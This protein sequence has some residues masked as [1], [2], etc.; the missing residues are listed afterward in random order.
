MTSSAVTRQFASALRKAGER[1]KQDAKQK[2]YFNDPVFWAE[3][4]LGL[5]LWSGQKKIL[6]S[7]AVN[8][9]TAVKSCHSIGKTFISAVASAWWI[10]TRDN[11]MVQS[12][13]PT[14]DQVHTLL[15]EEIRK[16]HNKAGLIGRVN[17]QDQWLKDTVNPETGRRQ[18]IV[19]GQGKKPADGN[20]HGF[21]GM[22]RPDGVFAIYDE[23]CGIAQA[24]FT[25]GEAITTGTQ[26]RQLTVGNPDDPATEFGDIFTTKGHLWNL[27]TISAYDTPNFTNE[28]EE[29]RKKYRNDPDKLAMVEAMLMGMPNVDTVAEQEELWGEDSPRFQSKVL[30]Q[31]PLVSEDSLFTPAEMATGISNRLNPEEN[32]FKVLGVDP[33]RYGNDKAAIALCDEGKVE[34]VATYNTMDLMELAARVHKFAIDL[35]VDQVRVDAV[36]L[37]GG[38]LDRL[39]ALNNAAGKTY[40][41]IE[42]IAGATPPDR[43]LHRNARA[44]WYDSFKHKLR[45]GNI[46]LP[47]S[48]DLLDEMSKVRYEYPNGVMKIESKEDMRKRGVHSP[49]ILDAVV[50][51]AAPIT[52]IANNPLA[53]ARPGQQFNFN[54]LERVRSVS[55]F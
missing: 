34:I 25:G 30:A 24:I 50:M 26:D 47:D 2:A 54:L 19:V 38:V 48:K 44:Y 41:V 52:S 53:S 15:W 4:K 18:Q 13:A 20:I 35:K 43:T 7:I 14:Y 27:I 39:V 46:D 21:H 3:D 32:S 45:A 49:D 1:V 12:T 8:K 23:G 6:Q 55:P 11:C 42:M 36:G 37:G 5:V 9:R 40:A 28:G 22:H 29:L 31:F 51:A 16:L 10:D 33:A 17:L